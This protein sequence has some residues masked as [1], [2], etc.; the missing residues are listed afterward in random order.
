MHT[1]RAVHVVRGAACARKDG[2]ARGFSQARRRVFGR[3]RQESTG[4]RVQNEVGNLKGH[5]V[6]GNVISTT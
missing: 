5:I 6:V 2:A 1:T 3:R 4:A